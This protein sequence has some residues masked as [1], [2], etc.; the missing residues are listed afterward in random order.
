MDSTG[1]SNHMQVTEEVYYLLKNFPYEF[2]CRGKIKVK[3]KGE[4][5]TYFIV[6]RAPYD[7]SKPPQ[8][9]PHKV[10]LE[11]LRETMSVPLMQEKGL[12]HAVTSTRSAI[13]PDSQPILARKLLSTEASFC[14]NAIERFNKTSSLKCA[15]SKEQEP[16]LRSVGCNVTAAAAIK[17]HPHSRNLKIILSK[18]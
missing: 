15:T 12:H 18:K 7:D 13:G 10:P 8:V 5:T 11:S 9:P 4:M 6:G 17:N 2:K 14:A 1:L 16:L 3:G